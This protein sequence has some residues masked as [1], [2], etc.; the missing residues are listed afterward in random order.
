[1]ANDAVAGSALR[2]APTGPTDG[3]DPVRAVLATHTKGLVTAAEDTLA[4][5]RRA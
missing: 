2:V 4:T 3:D 1:M 5:N